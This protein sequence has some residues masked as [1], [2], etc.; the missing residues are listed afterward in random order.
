MNRLGYKITLLAPVIISNAEADENMTAT[1]HSIPGSVLLGTF[2]ARYLEKKPMQNGHMDPNFYTWFLREGLCFGPAFPWI[3]DDDQS[4]SLYPLPFS[5]RKSKEP[6]NNTIYDVLSIDDNDLDSNTSSFK[7]YGETDGLALLKWEIE[8]KLQAHH[9]RERSTGIVKKGVFFFYEALQPGQEFCGEIRGETRD[10]EEFYRFFGS[11]FEARMGK[12]KNAEYGRVRIELEQ[13]ELWSKKEIQGNSVT[14]TFIS[15][16]I[17]WNDYG[18]AEPSRERLQAYLQGFLGTKTLN[19][20]KAYLGDTTVENYLA[21][22]RMK[23]PAEKA[24]AAGSTCK[25]EIGDFN[26]TVK[27][28]LSVLAYTG[29]GERRKEGFGQLRINWLTRDDGIYELKDMKKPYDTGS[30]IPSVPFPETARGIFHEV[31]WFHLTLRIKEKALMDIK[32]YNRL[33]ANNLL[34][35]LLLTLE[36]SENRGG[37]LENIE[38]WKEKKAYNDLLNCK[39]DNANLAEALRNTEKFINIIQSLRDDFCKELPA[40]AVKV[41]QNAPDELGIDGKEFYRIY[42]LYWRMV[43]QEMRKKNKQ[44]E[45]ERREG[46]KDGFGK[47]ANR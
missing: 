37:F 34:G 35:R 10:L 23:R 8:T 47:T 32:D 44:A 31:F 39:S 7:G 1:S 18:Y 30:I 16:C 25:L 27:E 9:E 41:I 22:W 4:R 13:P 42:R 3:Q 12:S 40:E 17:L 19:I 11:G 5:L 15:P 14:I 46:R 6:D 33:P 21:V 36:K 45:L 38:E 24:L 43:I 28:R 2:A 26:D 20:S 29:L